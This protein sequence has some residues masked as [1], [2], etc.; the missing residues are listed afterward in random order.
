MVA[1]A[2]GGVNAAPALVGGQFPA[3]LSIQALFP[4]TSNPVAPATGKVP[5]SQRLG[6][7]GWTKVTHH[8]GSLL[9]TG[10]ATR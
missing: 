7:L 6:P 1:K 5:L 10:N 8:A 3:R 2:R 4:L 9:D